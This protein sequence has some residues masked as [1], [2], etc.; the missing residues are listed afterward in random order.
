MSEFFTALTQLQGGVSQ[1]QAA[2]PQKQ[3]AEGSLGATPPASA[4][5]GD[6]KR[7]RRRA[8]TDPWQRCKLRMRATS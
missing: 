4:R 8:G 2:N 5:A 1:Q 6:M 7:T 3:A